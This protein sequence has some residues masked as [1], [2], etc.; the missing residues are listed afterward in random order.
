MDKKSLKLFMFAFL[1]GVVGSLFLT[2]TGF[3]F[4]SANIGNT[5]YSQKED[6]INTP[7]PTPNPELWEK[8]VVKVSPGLVGIQ[9]IS[10]NSV[11]RQG[12]GIIVSSDGLVV[13][14][15]NLWGPER[16]IYQ[17][18]YDNKIIKGNVVAI[19]SKA[20]LM[21]L[22]TPTQSSNIAELAKYEYK[23]GQEI[24]VVGK[25]FNLSKPTITSQ[26]GSISQVLEKSVTID[27]LPNKYLYGFGVS[28]K[29]G[30]LRGIVYLRSGMANLI[31]SE[32]IENFLK[33]YLE[34]PK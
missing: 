11:L 17:I 33:S 31:R 7:N 12:G 2:L 29:D 18:F 8:V 21:L 25:T 19:D 23:S 1:G 3:G 5:T 24:I 15:T 13:T 32:T 6:L 22:K 28:D 9:T 20:N 16:S 4:M 34:K 26:K 30:Y 27:T 14:T 10:E